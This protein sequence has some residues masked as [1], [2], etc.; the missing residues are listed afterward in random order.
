M[1]GEIAMGWDSQLKIKSETSDRLYTVSRNDLTGLWG[2]SCPGW[3]TTRHCK[4]LQTMGLPTVEPIKRATASRRSSVGR[5]DGNSFADTGEHYDTSTGLGNRM[6]WRKQAERI[7]AGR[8][9]RKPVAPAAP[10][11]AGSDMAEALALVGLTSLPDTAD[12]LLAAMKLQAEA[13]N[14]PVTGNPDKF[15]RMFAAYERLMEE[16]Y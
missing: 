12:A 4:H 3:R 9:A 14:H 13:L 10:P 6:E 8:Y 16:N 2:C 1:E 5:T 7:A 11:A 15:W